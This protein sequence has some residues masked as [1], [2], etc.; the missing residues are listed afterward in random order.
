MDEN[1]KLALKI[2]EQER[3]CAYFRRVNAPKVLIDGAEER[4]QQM[5]Q[6]NPAAVQL[7]EKARDFLR[8]EERRK[9]DLDQTVLGELLR[10]IEDLWDAALQNDPKGLLQ[11]DPRG[12]TRFEFANDK[13]HLRD[14]WQ[15]FLRGLRDVRDKPAFLEALRELVS[16]IK[17]DLTHQVLSPTPASIVSQ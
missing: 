9:S 16:T 11:N 12:S 5:I 4:L 3:R 6:K 10:A 17:V 8:A 2:A 1:L 15:E 14:P 7:L 13:Y